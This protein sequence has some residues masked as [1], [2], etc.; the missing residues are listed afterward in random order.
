[1]YV[2]WQ[3]ANANGVSSPIPFLIGETSDVVED[4]TATE[5]QRLPSLPAIVSGRLLK[6]QGVDRYKFARPTEGPITCEPHPRRLGSKF[7]GILEVRD[8]RGRL[9][10]DVLGSHSADPIVTFPAKANAEY[11][12]S[13]HDVDFAGDRSFV[14]RLSVTAGPR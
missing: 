1:G 12:V 8:A 2:Y 9:I 7:L 6:N 10:A 14:Y 4:E 13:I 11:T 5:G 3:V